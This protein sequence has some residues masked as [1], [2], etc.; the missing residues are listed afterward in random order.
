MICTHHALGWHFAHNYLNLIFLTE[1]FC[2]LNKIILKYV[3]KHPLRVS[4]DLTHWGW[5]THMCV[6]NISI[7]GSDNGLSPGRR[8]AIIWTNI[9][10][11]LIEP[12]ATSFSEILIRIHT[13]S[14]RKIHLK[15]SSG[16]WRP[17]C[18]GL[19]VLSN[20]WV[21]NKQQAITSTMLLDATWHCQALN[22]ELQQKPIYYF[23]FNGNLLKFIPAGWR[24]LTFESVA[25]SCKISSAIWIMALD[26]WIHIQNHQLIEAQTKWLPFRRR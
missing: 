24:I 17:C 4:I 1:N 14:F 16:K 8:W 20:H 2:I 5:V 9:V 26:K 11:L 7:I 15:M 10:I 22:N 18:L 23:L 12:L 6:S 19:N 25:E 13:F 3:P 21:T